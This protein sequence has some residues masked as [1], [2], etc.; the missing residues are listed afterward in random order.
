MQTQLKFGQQ[1]KLT[2]R[3]GRPSRC[4]AV[5]VENVAELERVEVVERKKV[6]IHRSTPCSESTP[7]HICAT[8]TPHLV[9]FALIP[10]SLAFQRVHQWCCH[11]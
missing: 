6:W 9:A 1:A 8:L 10:R 11:R 7:T 3:S 4:L 5:R 2:A